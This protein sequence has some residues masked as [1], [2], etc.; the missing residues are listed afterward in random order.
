MEALD[1]K[2]IITLGVYILTALG[3]F[4]KMKV[5]LAQIGVEIAEIKCDRIKRWDKHDEKS[6]EKQAK[7]DAYLSDILKVVTSVET[8]V[9]SMK[10]DIEWLKKD[11]K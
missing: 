4:I 7:N 3:I 8:A 6:D 5:D 9:G 11:K 1:F 10:T 2:T